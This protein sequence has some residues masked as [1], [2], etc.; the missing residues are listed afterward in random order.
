MAGVSGSLRESHYNNQ[1]LADVARLHYLRGYLEGTHVELIESQELTD[2][3]FSLA[4]EV[5]TATY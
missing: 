2:S 1:R 5:L 4:W 3:T